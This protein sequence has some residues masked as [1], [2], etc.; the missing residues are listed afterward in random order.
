MF[1]EL[2]LELES[3][4]IICVILLF[5]RQQESRKRRCFTWCKESVWN[6]NWEV[7]RA[8]CWDFGSTS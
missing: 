3:S 7:W 8:K 2:V 6:K 5:C 1:E 4:I